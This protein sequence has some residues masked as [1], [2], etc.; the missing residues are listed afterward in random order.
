MSIYDRPADPSFLAMTARVDAAVGTDVLELVD[1]LVRMMAYRD[2]ATAEHMD[3]VGTLSE[4]LALALDL[5]IETVGRIKC[6]GRLHDMGKI[7]IPESVLYKKGMLNADE[8]DQIRRHPGHG[9]N[10]INCYSKL[11]HLAPIVRAHHERMDGKGYPERRF[12]YETPF[13]ARVIAITDAFHAMTANRAYT[14]PRTPNDAIAEI[15]RC[16]G[17][18]F[19]GEFVD[20]FVTMMGFRERRNSA[21]IA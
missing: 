15:M 8:W 6:A 9:E 2:E 1:A 18:Q 16:R 10:I 3:A 21:N 14:E 20:V 5:P 13:E 11:A 4:R 12:G 7:T 19:D 17:T